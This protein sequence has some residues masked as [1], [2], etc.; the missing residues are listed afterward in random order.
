MP[1]PWRREADRRCP[2]ADCPHRDAAGD[3]SLTDRGLGPLTEAP[4]GGLGLWGHAHLNDELVTAAR[5]EI[6]RLQAGAE[7]GAQQ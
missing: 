6:S 1:A 2:A 4:K 3:S 7:Q 5:A